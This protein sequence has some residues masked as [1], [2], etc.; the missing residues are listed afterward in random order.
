MTISYIDFDDPEMK[1]ALHIS[2]SAAPKKNDLVTFTTEPSKV[3]E[4]S[5]K[6]CPEWMKKAIQ[7]DR[8]YFSSNEIGLLFDDF[9]LENG[10]KLNHK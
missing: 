6:N 5:I 3:N 8:M 4:W 10:I 1:P 2:K 7:E 9:M